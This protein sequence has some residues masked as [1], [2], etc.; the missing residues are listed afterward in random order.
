MYQNIYFQRNN[1]TIH[2]WDDTQG[3]RTFPYKRYAFKR[4]INGEWESIYGDKLVKVHKFSKDEDGLFESDVPEVTRVLV[5]TYLESDIPS[6]G[7]RVMTFDIEVE[8]NSGLPDTT[9]A[10][11]AITSIAVHDSVTDYYYVLVLDPKQRVNKKST[12]NHTILP[13][14]TEEEMLSK[15]LTIYEGINPTI[16]TGWNIDFFDVPYLFLR[17]KNLLGMNNARR[18]SPIKE[19]FYSP[20]RKRWFIGGVSALDYIVLYKQYTFTQ[21]DNYRLDT[22][23]RLEVGRGKVEY[24]GN[25]DQLMETDIEKF[26]EYNLEDVKLVV[27]MNRKLQFIDLCRGI[28][29][30]GHVSYEDVFFSSR[31]MEGALLCFLRKRGLVLSLIHI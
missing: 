21:L 18:L 15:F 28:A 2:I 29:H 30:A 31:I 12:G 1:N 5:D 24:T 27:D 9:K 4:A 14:D 26:I 11:N 7:H 16:I 23:A 10:E 13:F 3:H 19:V 17:M 8:M 6:V 22:V 25:L 20:Y